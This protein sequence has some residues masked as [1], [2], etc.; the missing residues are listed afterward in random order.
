MGP[1]VG[2][3][4]EDV[5]MDVLQTFLVEEYVEERIAGREDK[6]AAF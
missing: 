5:P 2:W 1:G 3:E 6:K 4:D